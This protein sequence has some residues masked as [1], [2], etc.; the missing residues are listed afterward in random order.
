MIFKTTWYFWWS[1]FFQSYF[2][3]GSNFFIYGWGQTCSARTFRNPHTHT[4]LKIVTFCAIFVT[5]WS[6][7]H[8]MYN[9]MCSC[10]VLFVSMYVCVSV[11][12]FIIE[13]IKNIMSFQTWSCFGFLSSTIAPQK[14]IIF[15]AKITLPVT[16][17][18]NPKKDYIWIYSTPPVRY[19]SVYWY[20]RW[21]KNM[22]PTYDYKEVM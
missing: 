9:V 10:P 5:K 18:W 11:R 3:G 8:S 4:S 15:S 12:S 22:R 6:T 14:L 19:C 1:N 20:T 7:V 2:R 16:L 21:P 17:F 13:N